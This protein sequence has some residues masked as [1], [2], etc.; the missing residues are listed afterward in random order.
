MEQTTALVKPRDNTEV[1][2]FYNEAL[3]LQKYAEARVITTA[4]D[5]KPATDDLSIIAKVKKALEGKRK[6]Y[7]VPLQ[8]QVK[9][10]NEAFKTLM[11][12]ILIADQVTR[13]KILAYQQEQKRIRQEQERINALRIEAAEKEAALNNGEITESVN[14][15]EVV[16]EAPKRVSTEMGTV[17]QR[18]IRKWEVID[19]AQVPE[20]Y[21]VIDSARVTKVVKAGIPS[22]PGIRI[23]EEPTLAVNVR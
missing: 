6:E 19:M 21:K 4:E 16:S 12:P 3:G 8:D 11:E 5:L 10:F 15:V 2:A 18:M 20:E 23:Y 22:I 13:E 9:E 17:G 7:V 14:L 1:M